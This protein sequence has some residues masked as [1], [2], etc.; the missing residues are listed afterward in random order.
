MIFYKFVNPFNP[1]LLQCR[2][3][4]IDLNSKLLHWF[5]HN[6]ITRLKLVELNLAKNATY[7]FCMLW[8]LLSLSKCQFV[9]GTFFFPHAQ[10][11]NT[12]GNI[13]FAKNLIKI[14]QGICCYYLFGPILYSQDSTR[15]Q[16]ELLL[17]LCSLLGKW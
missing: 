10:N 17:L 9:F 16:I 3:Q 11:L 6:S 8:S 7:A 14:S 2:N 15:K 4:S 13:F 5:L 1:V 12:I